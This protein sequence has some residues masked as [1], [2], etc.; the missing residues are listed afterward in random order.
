MIECLSCR[1]RDGRTE[2][3]NVAVLKKNILVNFFSDLKERVGSMVVPRF[4]TEGAG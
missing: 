1:D 4:Q 2:M 3:C